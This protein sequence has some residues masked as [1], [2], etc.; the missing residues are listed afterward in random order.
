MRPDPPSD[1]WYTRV[2]PQWIEIWNQVQNEWIGESSADIDQN[3]AHGFSDLYLG[4]IPVRTGS[5]AFAVFSKLGAYRRG[6]SGPEGAL[7]PAI[8]AVLCSSQGRRTNWRGNLRTA[9]GRPIR[10]PRCSRLRFKRGLDGCARL[11]PNVL[12][13]PVLGC[14][15]LR[16]SRFQDCDL[17]F[18][19]SGEF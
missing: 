6:A 18:R 17:I 5:E 3:T 8:G 7:Q 16:E 15:S 10:L 19:A 12:D 1:Y 4:R 14:R 2:D 9:Y 11:F 13:L